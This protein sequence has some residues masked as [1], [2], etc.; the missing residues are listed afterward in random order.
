MKNVIKSFAA[1]AASL[2]AFNACNREVLPVGPS[3]THSLS[4][5][6]D[7][8]QTKTSVSHEG[9]EAV[10][11]WSAED[12]NR[13]NV[14]EI[15]GDTYNEATSIEAEIDD[16]TMYINAKFGGAATPGAKYFAVLNTGIKEN[17]SSTDTSYDQESDVLV[18]EVVTNDDVENDYLTLC[19]KRETAFALMTAKQLEGSYLIGASIAADKVLA[20]G[21]DYKEKSFE[22]TGSNSIAIEAISPVTSGSA[23]VFF[24][25]VPVENATLTVAVVTVDEEERFVAAYEKTFTTPISFAR[26][27]VHA[28]GT[29]LAENKV[30]S[31]NLDLSTD[32]TTSASAD[33]LTWDKTFVSVVSAKVGSGT[34]ADNYYPGK[35][36]NSTRFYKGNTLTIS[37]KI[38][39]SVKEIIY[40]AT[41]EGYAT[42]LAT[43]EWTNATASASGT[44]VTIIPADGTQ[45]VSATMSNTTGATS[46]VIRYGVPVQPTAH[47]VTIDPNIEHGSVSADPSSDVMPGTEVTLTATPDDNYRFVSWT[48]TAGGDE[49]TVNND[50]FNMPND[51]VVVSASFELKPT[52]EAT[53]TVNLNAS[54]Y[55]VSTGN[56]GT[57][58]SKTTTDGITVVSGCASN[59]ST[60]TSYQS[61]HIRYY[62]SS[63]LK[64][65]APDGMVVTSIVFAEP[66]S[67]KKWD[68]TD[69]AGISVDEGT[70]TNSTKSWSGSS[71]EV[72]FS[73][74][75]QCRVASIDVTVE[76]G[77]GVTKYNVSCATVTGGTLSADPARAEAGT[78]ITLTATPNDEYEFNNDWTVKDASENPVTVTD[79]KF[80]MPASEVSVS[81]SFSKKTYAITATP[82]EHGTYTVKV[83]GN[84]VTSASKGDK[85]YLDATPADGYLCDGWT[86]TETV[87]GATVSVSNNSFT[88]PAAAVT[89]TTSFSEKPAE[90]EYEGSGTEEDPYTVD[91][92]IKL[93]NTLGTSSSEEVCVKGTISQVDS[94]NSTYKSI[95]YWLDG[96]KLEVYSGKNLNNTDFASKDDLAVGDQVVVKGNLKKYNDTYEFDKNNYIVSIKKAPYLKV[97]ADKKDGISADGETV[98]VNVNTNVDGWTATSDNANFSISGKTTNSF[99]VVVA[100]NS[101]SDERSAKI[102]VSAAGVNPVEFTMTQSAPGETHGWV[103]C[104]TVADITSG[105]KFIIGYEATANSGKLI[106]MK[107]T[108]GTA[109]TSAAGYMASGS[110]IDMANVTT[111]SEY[112]FTI[113]ASTSVTGAVCIKC[114]DDF[115]GNTNT[116]NNLKLFTEEASTTAFGVTVGTNDVFTFKIAANASYHTLQYNTGSPRFAVYGGA[117]KNLVV[118]KYQ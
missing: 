28:F 59:A 39:I 103:R 23:P 73:F 56:N 98:T 10:Y 109:T 76:G 1:L 96:N 50:K 87:G 99:Q 48:V 115:I 29:K 20:A 65:T 94:Y 12:V 113:V 71:E 36:Q 5:V 32:Q 101:T 4:F 91:D 112:E 11:S 45:A 52:D 77:S 90:I 89:I 107:N 92:A 105:G 100:K 37:P 78:E 104:T 81:G 27:D 93:I 53:Y 60:K 51:D 7:A 43:S 114:G 14:Y 75:A 64:V 80:T 68:A 116:K 111:T 40:E 72:T 95:Q 41:T 19:F 35:N 55:G 110:E 38:G 85:V 63:Y 8:P 117:Q 79:S 58:Q 21:Y 108:G 62:T 61:D 88:M 118:Y 31:L 54:L 86:V 26:G 83:G 6:A 25:T 84:D 66:S 13:F 74:S 34:N 18:S 33:A 49:I 106:P 22:T 24:A 57:E 44:T 15:V 16:N 30:T 97:S 2:L 82:A 42:A 47:S 102:T 46:I 70:Y 67:N 9:N 17:Q 3:E 69:Q